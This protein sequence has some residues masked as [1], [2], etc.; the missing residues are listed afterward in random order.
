MMQEQDSKV[1][2][3]VTNKE[4]ASIPDDDFRDNYTRNNASQLQEKIKALNDLARKRTSLVLSS[5]D[6]EQDKKEDQIGNHCET[7]TS[8]LDMNH[9]YLLNLDSP[10]MTESSKR[11]QLMF[12][13]YM[14]MRD[15]KGDIE[16][17]ANFSTKKK[18]RSQLEMK[19]EETRKRAIESIE[20]IL[21]NNS[22]LY[23]SR[24]ANSLRYRI[25]REH[26]A[27]HQNH[28]IPLQEKEMNPT[29]LLNLSCEKMCVDSGKR[30]LRMIALHDSSQQLFIHMYWLVHC[31]FFQTNSGAEQRYLLEKVAQI[32]P[33]FIHA[34][35]MVTPS[36]HSDFIYRYYPFL[37]AKAIGDGFAFLCPGNPTLFKGTF[38]RLLHLTV[39]RMFTG[40]NLC[41][42]SIDAQRLEVFPDDVKGEECNSNTE[43]DES[44]SR[45]GFRG[46]KIGKDRSSANTIP[47]QQKHQFDAYQISPLLQN[48]LK[49]P[50]VSDGRSHILSR[51]EPIANCKSGGV[52][53]YQSL[54]ETMNSSN[55]DPGAHKQMTSELLR[56]LKEIKFKSRKELLTITK[57]RTTILLGGADS[58]AKFTLNLLNT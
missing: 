52:D 24:C 1:K 45:K 41:P 44:S 46:T 31:R 8:S 16:N 40:L 50:R 39:F 6:D 20:K 42:A 54:R 37:L 32:F 51:T 28:P 36:N 55:C 10:S 56:D 34:A 4:I 13:K 7:D 15:T 11:I 30:I 53:T 48:C 29:L 21:R 58:V 43:N 22:S 57:D 5:C 23:I 14:N 33:Q 38:Q 35:N 17:Q 3:G 19:R 47:R 49:R 26:D 18:H 27:A 9:H 2:S 25:P 12:E